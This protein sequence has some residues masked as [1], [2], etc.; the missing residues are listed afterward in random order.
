MIT[1]QQDVLDVSVYDEDGKFLTELKFNQKVGFT[2]NNRNEN[3]YLSIQDAVQNLGM[4]SLLGESIE[5]SIKSDFDANT[6][7]K[8]D[9]KIIKFNNS[10]KPTKLKLVATGL[11][12]NT[13]T[14]EIEHDIK[15]IFP[16]VELMKEHEFIFKAGEA[17]PPSYSFRIKPYNDAGDLYE[18]QFKKRSLK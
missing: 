13:D 7:T 11:D 12:Y 3:A 10:S 8:P 15:I 9:V 2:L 18:M 4:L 16:K 6:F 17:Q 5:N 1:V 14:A